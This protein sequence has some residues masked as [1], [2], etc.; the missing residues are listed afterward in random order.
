MILERP[1]DELVQ[2]IGGQEL[3][4][5]GAGERRGKR[6]H[7]SEFRRQGTSKSFEELNAPR[8]CC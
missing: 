8:H 3:M 2:E 7:A 5:I 6:L 4:N 1:F